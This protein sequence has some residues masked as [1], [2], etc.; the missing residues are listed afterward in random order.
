MSKSEI[1]KISELFDNV[2]PDKYPLDKYSSIGRRGIKRVDGYEKA[3]GAARYTM[4]IQIPGM[5]Y[6]RFLTSP[7][8]HAEIR[9]M[10]TSDAEALEGVRAILRYD[11]AD[12]PAAVDLGGHEP[13]ALPVLPKIAHFQGEETGAFVA[14]D[15]EEIAEHAL[16]LIKVDWIQRPFVLD[17]EAALQP[18]S[19]LANPEY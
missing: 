14:A 5:L 2:K 4:D 15:S 12:L 6:G 18:G 10:D 11:D 13:S 1:Q 7:Y 8:P 3:S 19:P 17:V 9:S 16:A